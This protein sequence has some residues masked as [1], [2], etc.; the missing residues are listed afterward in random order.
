MGLIVLSIIPII[1]VL[2]VVLAIVGIFILFV[3]EKKKSYGEVYKEHK[4]QRKFAKEIRKEEYSVRNIY[5]VDNGR[6][7]EI[8]Q[9]IVN[10]TGIY[11][12][13]NKNHS[14]II[15]GD[16]E[17]KYWIQS[18]SLGRITHKLYNPILQNEGHVK[19][20]S[21]F[22]NRSDCIYSL[23]VFH[24]A[25]L[26]VQSKTFVGSPLAAR[27]LINNQKEIRLSVDEVRLIHA[28]L[29]ELSRNPQITH[30]EHVENVKRIREKYEEDHCPI[31]GAPLVHKKS[32]FEEFTRCSN[33]PTCTY[34]DND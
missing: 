22:L 16:E 1:V 30:E 20:L 19:A 31:C 12:I 15:Y 23:I 10:Q 2:V 4:R 26:K 9:V 32:V 14:G 13:E 6:S 28:K 25:S 27:M 24:K 8:D 3:V 29:L 33:Y 21:R 5:I 34:I 18:L 7:T 11:V 17:E